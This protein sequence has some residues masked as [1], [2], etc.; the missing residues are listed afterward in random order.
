MP[1]M[2]SS[3]D[4][5]REGGIFRVKAFECPSAAARKPV[6]LPDL[7]KTARVAAVTHDEVTRTNSEPAC[8][9]DIDRIGFRK[10]PHGTPRH[11]GG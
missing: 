4:A 10:R 5:V 8:D 9:P 11:T 2:G 6:L 7:V 3:V 1:D